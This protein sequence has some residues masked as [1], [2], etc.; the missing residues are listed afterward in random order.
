MKYTLYCL[1]V[2]TIIFGA[3]SIYFG[4]ARLNYRKRFGK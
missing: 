2:F 1:S 4:T 3:A